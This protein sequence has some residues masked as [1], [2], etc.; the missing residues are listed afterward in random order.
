LLAQAHR[1]WNAN[2]CIE[3]EKRTTN[4]NTSGSWMS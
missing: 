2:K 1:L 4:P 3:S